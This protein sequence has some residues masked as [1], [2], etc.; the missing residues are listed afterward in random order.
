[1]DQEG[2]STIPLIG[3]AGA[4]WTVAC[5]MIQGHGHDRQFSNV[6]TR[7]EADPNF[8]D[9]V[10]ST[11]IQSTI[12]YLVG[13]IKHGAGVI[14]IFD[15]WAGIVPTRDMD[16]LIIEPT[17]QI[18]AG[19]RAV[20]P[21]VPIIGFPRG[22]PA[23]FLGRYYQGTGVTAL[24]LGEDIHLNNDLHD[25]DLHIPVQGNLAPGVLVA[26]GADLDR[27]IDTILAA[28]STRPHIFNLGHGITPDTPLD[29]V[30]QLIKRVRGLS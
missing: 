14:Q 17:R 22:L 19:V 12:P 24:G 21:H 29:H 5:Y 23:S 11:I 28:T 18:V 27:A 20:Y 25:L 16:R 1:L 2:F 8:I 13:Q 3:F 26:G 4:P 9:H 7:A 10:L 6:R 30:D 15:S